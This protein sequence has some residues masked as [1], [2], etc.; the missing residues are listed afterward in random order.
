MTTQDEINAIKAQIAKS[1]SD[2]RTWRISG[3]VESSIEAYD[4]AEA[5][6]LR[7]EAKLAQSKP[8]I[9]KDRLPVFRSLNALTSATVTATDGSI[10][11]VTSA[12]FDDKSWTIRYL[13]LDAGMWL[14]S[15]KV[16]ISPYAVITPFSSDNNIDVTLTR[17][18]VES[19]PSIDTHRPVTRQHE[20]EHLRHFAYPEYWEGD[21]T[22]GATQY[23]VV[24]TYVPSPTEIE[25]ENAMREQEFRADDVHLQSSEK[26]TGYD[27]QATDDSIGHVKDFIFDEAS[28]VIRY[29]VVDTRNWWPGGKSVLV[30]THWIESIDWAKSIVRVKLA[31]EQIRSSP[32]YVDAT[33]IDRNYEERLHDTHERQGYWD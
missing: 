30:A 25:V 6:Q 16:L 22:W 21:G 26:V 4:D 23:P 15:R 12:L 10:G 29:L 2:A 7:L 1:E 9:E 11:D 8:S 19:S 5:A 14:S 17:Q 18:Q 28:W 3:Y 31:R 27:I 13:V 32:E 20:R 33:M 24:R